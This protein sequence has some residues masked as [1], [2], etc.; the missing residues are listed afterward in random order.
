M[1]DIIESHIRAIGCVVINSSSRIVKDGIIDEG[2]VYALTD[3]SSIGVI[4]ENV[5]ANSVSFLVDYINAVA[6][7]IFDDI[8]RNQTIRV[9]VADA[10]TG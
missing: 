2:D 6:L 3:E 8:I 1:T 9:A 7:T 4:I 10:Y 5:M